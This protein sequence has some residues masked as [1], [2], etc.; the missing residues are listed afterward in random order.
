MTKESLNEALIDARDI[1]EAMRCQEQKYHLTIHDYLNSQDGCSYLFGMQEAWR[2]KMCEWAYGIV[3]H[4]QYERSV[5]SIAFHYID[6]FLSLVAKK[7]NGEIEIGKNQFQLIAL[8]SVYIAFKL[9]KPEGRTVCTTRSSGTLLDEFVIMSRGVFVREDIEKMEVSLL[10]NL[11]WE[12]NPPTPAMFIYHLFK[13]ISKQQDDQSDLLVISLNQPRKNGQLPNDSIVSECL[14][15]DIF[16]HAIFFSELAIASYNISIF[17]SPFFIALGSILGAIESAQQDLSSLT[18]ISFMETITS[19]FSLNKE[20]VKNAH[21][22]SYYIIHL[23]SSLLNEEEL[24]QDCHNDNIISPRKR[25]HS[26]S[27]VLHFSSNG[28][29]NSEYKKTKKTY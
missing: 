25:V 18:T 3:D 28:T 19:M 16:D 20:E 23:Y 5:V 11:K 1:L 22:V 8:T 7:Y 12:M 27:C 24:Y 6:R 14:L 29:S 13:H 4:F 10:Q 21:Q 9:N 15:A 26:P 17:Q 2:T